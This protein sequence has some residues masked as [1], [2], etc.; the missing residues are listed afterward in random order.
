[1]GRRQRVTIALPGERRQGRRSFLAKGL[2]GGALLAVGGGSF[3]AT[4]KTVVPAGIAADLPVFSR[5]EVAVLLAIAERLVPPRPGFPRP[6]DVELAARLDGVAAQ[7]D[8]ATQRELKQL[9]R[10]FESALAGFLLDGQARVFT[11]SS[12]E[13]Q[14]R[15]LAAWARSRLALRRTGHRALRRVVLAAYY[16]SPRTWDAVGY[17]GPPLRP[18]AV[19][20]ASTRK[21]NGG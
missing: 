17:P 20:P 14:D 18:G 15:R 3:L 6:A 7:A 10:L 1:M 5:E 16:S 13:G 12:P 21:V 19:A 9:V 8:P 11:A 4:R 2:V